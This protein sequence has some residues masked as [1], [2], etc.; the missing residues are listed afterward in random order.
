MFLLTCFS[1]LF[2]PFLSFSFSLSSSLPQNC[3][4]TGCDLQDANLRGAN[5]KN[6]TFEEMLTPLH[7]SQSVAGNYP[8]R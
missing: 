8:S 3:N 1:L 6:A 7:M 5:V 4:L 2:L